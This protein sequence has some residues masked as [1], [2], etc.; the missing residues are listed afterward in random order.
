MIYKLRYFYRIKKDKIDKNNKKLKQYAR[1]TK[2]MEKEGL[3]GL[4]FRTLRE[5]AQN[6]PAEEVHLY[7][8]AARIGRR[9]LEGREVELP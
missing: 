1:K 7:E 3:S 9:I 8:L 6:A 2:T 4:F 5:G